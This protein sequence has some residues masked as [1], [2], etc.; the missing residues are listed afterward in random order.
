MI[1]L[2]SKEEN[3]FTTEKKVVYP[4]KCLSLDL[5]MCLLNH[6]S[7]VF[8]QIMG[9]ESIYRGIYYLMLFN[10]GWCVTVVLRSPKHMHCSFVLEVWTAMKTSPIITGLSKTAYWSY[11][12]WW[13]L[14]NF[15][16][17]PV[18]FHLVTDGEKYT[19][20]AIIIYSY[21]KEEEDPFL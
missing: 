14:Y 5:G 13:E 1:Q 17:A 9:M 21:S 18:I 15:H 12:V 20:L 16:I 6:R 19:S 2:F 11:R 7:L 4:L 10:G 8:N 3:P